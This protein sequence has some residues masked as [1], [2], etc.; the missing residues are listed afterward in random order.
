MATDI[1]HWDFS[2]LNNQS[3]IFFFNKNEG[4]SVLFSRKDLEDFIEK[5]ARSYHFSIPRKI[6]MKALY[7]MSLKMIFFSQI[8]SVH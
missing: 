6:L 4:K 2:Y 1:S 5:G 8:R 3:S 7:N